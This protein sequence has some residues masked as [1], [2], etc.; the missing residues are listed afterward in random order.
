MGYF[1]VVVFGIWILVWG[2]FFIFFYFEKVGIFYV[3]ELIIIF[4]LI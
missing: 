1:S 3:F 4:W 2:I